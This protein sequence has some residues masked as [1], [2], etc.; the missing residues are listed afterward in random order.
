MGG[1]DV[2]RLRAETP[3]VEKVLHFNNAGAGL[4]PGPVLDAVTG[5]LQ[6]EAT[7]GGYEAAD[8]ARP[9]LDDT[10]DAIAGLINCH[11][12]EV[13]VVENATVAWNQAFYAVAETMGAGYRILTV[14]AE[15][16]SNFIQYLRLKETRGVETVIVPSTESGETDVARMTELMDDRVKLIS[17]CHIPTNGGLINPVAEIGRLARAA[18]VP[19]LLDACQSVGQIP[20]DV[21]EIGCDFLSVT[22][23]KYLRGPRGTGFLYASRR[24]MER[25]TPPVLDLHSA[26]WDA[27]DQYTILPGARRFENW[28]NYEAGKIGLGVAV[29]YLLDVGMDAAS[30]RL[31]GLAE[32]LRQRLSNLPGIKV[33]DLG[34]EKGG[35]VT[36]S[37]A[38]ADLE[39]LAQALRAQHINVSTTKATSTQI[40]MTRRRLDRMVRA[41]VHY[42]NTE[43]EIDRFVDAIGAL[44]R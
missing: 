32:S 15:Y 26:R 36:F 23:R 24:A 22:G 14:E 19:Y 42:Y 10:Y 1:L 37:H 21:A 11:R 4:M 12:D 13:A 18:D 6:L 7:H 44:T 8:I 25:F 27:V 31:T 33:R 9:R 41:S 34:R 29:R 17:V 3:G 2:D 40:D 16:A 20:V 39:K 43:S 5:H 30:K 28:E 35:I 38:E